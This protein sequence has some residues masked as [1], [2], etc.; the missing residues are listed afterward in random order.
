MRKQSV[1]VDDLDFRR[2][3]TSS[4]RP[5]DECK[6]RIFLAWHQRFSASGEE[7]VAFE[8]SGSGDERPESFDLKHTLG[9]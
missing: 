1:V 7:A 4:L 3:A 6:E 2:N 8:G 9:Y 5:I